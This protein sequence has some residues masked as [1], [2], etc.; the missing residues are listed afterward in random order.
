MT[1]VRLACALFILCGLVVLVINGNVAWLA[2]T[3]FFAIIIEVALKRALGWLVPI[4]LFCAALAALELVGHRSISALPLRALAS[5]SGLVLAFRVAPWM[6]LLRSVSPRSRLFVPVLF[7][8]FVL[9]F[10]QILRNEA[11]RS[12]TAYRLVVPHP[13]KRGGIR[14]LACSLDS[15]FHRGL[16]RAERFYAAQLLK[17]LAE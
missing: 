4:L 15:F 9:H 2:A 12:L 11:L 14:A 5:F 3:A 7:L 16:L 17:G 6:N 8:L 1:V 10:T 13:L